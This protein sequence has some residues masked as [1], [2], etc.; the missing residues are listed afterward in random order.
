MPSS[1]PVHIVYV[2]NTRLPTEKAH[3]LATVKL[4]EALARCGSQVDLVV[5]ALWFRRAVDPFA[6]YQVESNFKIHRIPVIDLMAFR[7]LEPLL[8]LVQ[9]VSFSLSAF[10]W[11][12]RRYGKRLGD[13]VFL[14]HDYMPLYALSRLS[15]A[16]LLYDVHHFPGRNFMYRRLLKRAAGFA[17]QTKWKIHALRERFGIAPERIVY[18]PNGTDVDAFAAAPE[19]EEARE[20]LGLPSDRKIVLYAGQFFEWKGV[21]TLARAVPEVDQGADVY[22]LGGSASDSRRLREQVP[23]ARD[24]RIR[25]VEFQ[26]RDRMPLWLRAADV[27]VLPNTGRSNV[28]RY[29]T[30]PMKLFEYMASGTPIVASAL[31]SILE[32]VGEE[33]AVLAEADNPQ[34]FAKKINWVLRNPARA[35]TL[36]RRAER[37]VRQYTWENRAR[38]IAEFLARLS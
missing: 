26:S 21:G 28:S 37:D 29:Y 30:S 13:V 25:C 32:I 38:Q 2:A 7:A 33:S 16:K 8:F 23:E 24:P 19:R 22:L 10:L 35:A 17:V 9:I 20:Q 18:W 4:C 27:L 31:P 1:K 11:C 15:G 5:P 14:S 36:G 6:H 12:S 3:G 34:D